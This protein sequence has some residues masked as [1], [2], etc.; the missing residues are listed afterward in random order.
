MLR[1]FFSNIKNKRSQLSGPVSH[2]E[3][4]N[5]LRKKIR[6]YSFCHAPFSG[7]YFR[8]DGNIIACCYNHSYILGTYPDQ[9]IREIWHGEKINFL[10]KELKQNNLSHGCYQCLDPL[11]S[12]NISSVKS[13]S[14]D[15]YKSKNGFPALM[16]FELDNTCNLACIMCNDRLSSCIEKIKNKDKINNP[17]DSKFTDQLD[18]FIPYLEEARFYGG[19]PFLIELYYSIWEHIIRLNPKCRINIQT[20]GTILT[21]RIKQL[22]GKGNFHITVS[23]DSVN[24]QNFESIRKNSKYETVLSN[25]DYYLEYSRQNHSHFGFSF[26]PLRQNWDEIPD[27]IRFANQKNTPVYF[28]HVWI[29]ADLSL[30]TLDSE[31]LEEISTYFSKFN[32]EKKTKIQKQNYS[33]FT[34]LKEQVSSWSHLAKKRESEELTIQ[35]LSTEMIIQRIF[36]KIKKHNTTSFAERFMKLISKV[37]PD[38]RD[39][40]ARKIYF[41]PAQHL[42]EISGFNSD[43]YIIEQMERLAKS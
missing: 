15:I 43:E 20:N 2:I 16:E 9:A 36:D 3:A 18:Y 8:H 25:V 14:Y 32:P 41:I 7:M 13:L 17:Y 31:K 27:F 30:W 35:K 34:R 24:K 38:E 19:E 33:E 28:H 42:I 37:N 21:D 23:I 11:Q 39:K 10:R 6:P 22:L 26:C 40:A 1:T 4:Y 12:G 29:P 5:N